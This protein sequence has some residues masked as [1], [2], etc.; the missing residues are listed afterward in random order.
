MMK[1]LKDL[2]IWSILALITF[3]I[4]IVIAFLMP[5]EMLSTFFGTDTQLQ[6]PAEILKY[7]GLIC[8]SFLVL[9]SL[10][11]SSKTNRLALQSNQLTLENNQLALQSNELTRKGQLDNRFIEASKLLAG[12]N[13]SEMLSGIYALHQIAVESS[14]KEDTKGY[15][16]V[17]KNILCA[18]LRENRVIERDSN[19]TIVKSEMAKPKIVFQ[20]IVDVL[21]KGNGPEIYKDTK[22]D[23]QEA[24]L[25][26]CNF[27][28]PDLSGAILI[29]AN[30]SRAILYR[31][32]LSEAGLSRADLSRV[33]LSRANL[34]RANLYRANLYGADLIGANLSGA[35]LSGADLTGADLTGADLTEA[36]LTGAHF[37][38]ADLRGSNFTDASF[39]GIIFSENKINKKTNFSGIKLDAGLTLE[40]LLKDS[41]MVNE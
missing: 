38:K 3:V 16:P 13:T 22:T 29:E 11:A 25:K 32:D 9:G 23:L 24:V 37:T 10:Q 5:K 12:E 8:G 2:S 26:D 27:I 41:K 14:A 35:N 31:A 33:N 15:V 36:H 39:R 1:R 18:F 19:H 20:T 7:A 28:F 21:F 4:S 6:T 40:E 34:S 17:I 30:L